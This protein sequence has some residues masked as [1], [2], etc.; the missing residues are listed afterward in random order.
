MKIH[1]SNNKTVYGIGYLGEGKFKSRVNG[2]MTKEYTS[3]SA[4]MQ[5]CYSDIYKT[6]EDTY[7]G[8]EVCEEWHNFQNFAKWYNENYYEVPNSKV[9]LDKDILAPNNKMYSPNT[10]IFVPEEINLVFS[11][12]NSK[13][14]SLNV[15]VDI[16]HNKKGDK[17]KAR[18]RFSKGNHKSSKIFD[19][20]EEAK[21]EY[22]RLK[23]QRIHELAEKYKEYIPQKLY[24]VLH[25]FDISK[26]DIFN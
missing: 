19:T 6:K 7:S 2:K 20:F 23:N 24:I 8:C 1:H 3:W 17:Y 11:K 21:E 5:R 4:M 18:C 22:I 14:G 13:N 12:N 25:D 15:G 26:R 16:V 9:Q 10:C